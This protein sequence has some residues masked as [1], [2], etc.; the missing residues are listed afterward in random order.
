[1]EGSLQLYTG[2][3]PGTAI[4]N[5]SGATISIVPSATGNGSGTTATIPEGATTSNALAISGGAGA[6]VTYSWTYQ[7]VTY[8][9]TFTLH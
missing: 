2:S 9:V 3:Y 4:P 8:K 5:E 7:S 1:M 6:V